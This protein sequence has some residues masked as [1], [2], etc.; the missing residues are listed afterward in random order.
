V[1]TIKLILTVV[2]G[3]AATISTVVFLVKRVVTSAIDSHF[4][5]LK[6][7][8]EARVSLDREWA[9]RVNEQSLLALPALLSLSYKAKL[10]AEQL[11]GSRTIIE[12]SNDTVLEAARELSA[13]LVSFRI[14]VEPSAF[15]SL[16]NFK[17]AV[18]DLRLFCD[19]LT[20]RSRPVELSAEERAALSDVCGRVV[21]TFAQVDAEV[22]ELVRAP[23]RRLR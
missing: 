22:G 17:H 16:H 8:L 11:A 1:E 23:Q 20:R 2:V 14:Y 18:Q 5:S 7:S 10:A 12:L 6:T 19:R 9:Q 13:T 4:E 3:S 21:M 15:T